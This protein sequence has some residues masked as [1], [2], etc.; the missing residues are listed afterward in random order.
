M[1]RSKSARRR[2]APAA[3]VGSDGDA[4]ASDVTVFD[5]DVDMADNTVIARP[6]GAFAGDDDA[7]SGALTDAIDLDPIDRSL[8]E[9]VESDT[10]ADDVDVADGAKDV[11]VVASNDSAVGTDSAAGT[12]ISF[13]SVSTDPVDADSPNGTL[14]T[15]VD[16]TIDS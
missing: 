10:V 3:S 14:G 9:G 7:V 16:G 11:S 1:A 15:V 13:Q 4:T 5:A 8:L 2:T 6:G 12:D